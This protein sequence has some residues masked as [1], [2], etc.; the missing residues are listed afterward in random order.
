MNTSNREVDLEK[1]VS[2]L[3]YSG[4]ERKLIN[5]NGFFIPRGKA[6]RLRDESVVDALDWLLGAGI[7]DG[8]Y[9][10][11]YSIRHSPSSEQWGE[12]LTFFKDEPTEVP[13]FLDGQDQT[14]S[15]FDDDIPF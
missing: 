7:G 14:S 5:G 4:I 3:A 9:I 2:W 8:D 1:L 10:A 15:D 13:D 11:G 6:V 12:K